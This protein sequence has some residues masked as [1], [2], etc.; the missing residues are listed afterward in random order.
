MRCQFFEM[1]QI[2]VSPAW[3]FD[4]VYL[5]SL[6]VYHHLVYFFFCLSNI[7]DYRFS[8]RKKL[9]CRIDILESLKENPAIF[10]NK[11]M[12]DCLSPQMTAA[13]E[14]TLLWE[15]IYST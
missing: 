7:E 11:D 15:S 13:E 2:P 14:L 5:Q 1:V 4:Q 6:R 10:L 12:L 9:N 3:L 8:R